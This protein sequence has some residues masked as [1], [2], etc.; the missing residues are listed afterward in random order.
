MGLRK[1]IIFFS[2]VL[3][4]FTFLSTLQS[5]CFTLAFH[6]QRNFFRKTHAYSTQNPRYFLAKSTQKSHVTCEIPR[7]IQFQLKSAITIFNFNVCSPLDP[8]SHL[9]CVLIWSIYTIYISGKLVKGGGH[10]SKLKMVINL[11][12]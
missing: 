9:Y 2:L 4:L 12:F 8:A 1:K 10:T 3:I 5:S 11:F 6:A 7:Q